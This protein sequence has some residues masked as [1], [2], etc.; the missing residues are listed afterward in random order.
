MVLKIPTQHI[1]QEPELSFKLTPPVFNQAGWR[2]NQNAFRITPRNEFTNQHACLNG[3]SKANL[4]RNQ[5][6]PRRHR[7]QIMHQQNLVRQQIH[8]A[9]GKFAASVGVGD[10]Q[11]HLLLA[12]GARRIKIVACEPLPQV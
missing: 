6:A 3:L 1:E 8:P 9:G 5:H 2:D 7:H 11:R 12:I 10:V 4:I